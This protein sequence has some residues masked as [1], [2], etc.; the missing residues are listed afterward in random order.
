MHLMFKIYFAF[1]FDYVPPEN[2][3]FYRLFLC[4]PIPSSSA[5]VSERVSEHLSRI[6]KERGKEG[7]SDCGLLNNFMHATRNGVIFCAFK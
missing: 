5:N 2:L 3:E 1:P 7:A 4:L 6:E